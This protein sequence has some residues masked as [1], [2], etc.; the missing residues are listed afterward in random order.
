MRTYK[1]KN[2]HESYFQAL[3]KKEEK[4]MAKESFLGLWRLVS[5]ELKRADGQVTFPLGKDAVGYLIYNES[6]HMSVA[7]MSASRPK[8]SSEVAQGGT[9][10]EKVTAFDTYLSYCGKYKVQGTKVIHHVEVSLYP[11]WV[12]VDL[13][14]AF[15]FEGDRLSLSAPTSSRSG[16]Q[17]MARLVWERVHEERKAIIRS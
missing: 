9:N 5:Y 16:V 8:F 14:R 13:E 11:N 7:I 3:E 4:K 6:G 15:E 12:G 17:Y 10:T 2:S 1:R